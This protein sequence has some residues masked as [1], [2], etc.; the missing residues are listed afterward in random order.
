MGAVRYHSVIWLNLKGAMIGRNAIVKMRKTFLS[1][2]QEISPENSSPK[3]P[4]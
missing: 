2:M 4:N 3:K 1:A